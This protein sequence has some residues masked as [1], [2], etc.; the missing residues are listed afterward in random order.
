MDNM[1]ASGGRVVGTVGVLLC[2]VSVILRSIGY[3]HF[4]GFNAGTVLQV[5]T[6][7]VVVACFLLLLTRVDR[8]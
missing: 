6:A 8:R 5:G 4:F 7:A 1:L 3:H 2:I